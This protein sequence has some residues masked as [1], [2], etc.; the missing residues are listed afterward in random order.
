MTTKYNA[1]LAFWRSRL[2]I[3]QG[4]FYNGHYERIMLAMA[5]EPDAEFVRGKVVADFGCGPRGSLVWA[6][7]ASLRI[8]IDVLADRY[9][10]E[11]TDNILSHGMIY[12]KSTEQVIPLPSAMVDILFTM[13]AIDHVDHF[14][15]MCAEIVRVLK[16][17]GAFIGSFNLEEPA[18]S[19]EPQHLTEQQIK[20]SLLDHLQVESYRVSKSGPIGH[21]YE[22]FYTDPL[23]Y[24][25][26]HPGILWVR[27][28]KPA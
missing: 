7:T 24:E 28:R 17:G 12:L 25:P 1:E 21:E 18:S 16:P 5:Q 26:G 20:E 8:G 14:E 6:S 23:T 10:D 15:K 2:E 3:N 19:T 22:P 9:A 13:N 11:F 4:N 27:A